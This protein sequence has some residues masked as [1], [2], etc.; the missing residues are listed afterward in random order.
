MTITSVDDAKA[1]LNITTDADDA[2]LVDKIAAAE[3][4]VAAFLDADFAD[5]EEFPDGVIPAPIAEAIRQLTAHLYENREV[6]ARRHQR[7]RA[8]VRRLRP[9]R[10]V[11][12][13]VL[14]MAYVHF[15]AVPIRSREKWRCT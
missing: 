8:P 4:W 12:R 5:E 15:V 13:L 7:A 14:L 6:L 9:P 3:A 11:S 10:A 1:H 2:L